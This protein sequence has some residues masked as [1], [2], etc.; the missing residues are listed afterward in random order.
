MQFVFLFGVRQ[1]QSTFGKGN[2][3]VAAIS[4]VHS[5]HAIRINQP[6]Y[7]DQTLS[8]NAHQMKTGIYGHLS[9]LV[10][11]DHCRS[12]RQLT[13]SISASTDFSDHEALHR[14]RILNEPH[15][16]ADSPT[17]E[18]T[19]DDGAANSGSNSTEVSSTQ[20]QSTKAAIEIAGAKPKPSFE[21][22]AASENVGIIR[23]FIDFLIH[24]K[25]WWLTPIIVILLLV[26]V[27]IALTTSGAAPFLYTFW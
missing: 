20:A 5:K 22:L 26:G 23:E 21:Q 10:K 7:S 1:R 27:M 19:A 15:E 18:T 8:G 3:L 9:F 14:A 12:N 25:K 6:T 4:L 16:K 24:N 13:S 17:N 2:Q 11:I